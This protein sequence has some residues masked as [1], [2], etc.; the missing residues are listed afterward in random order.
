MNDAKIN[1]LRPRLKASNS[2][3]VNC[4]PHGRD[5]LLL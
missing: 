5:V 2:S 3:T 1:D 4:I